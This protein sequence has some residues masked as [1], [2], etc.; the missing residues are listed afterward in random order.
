M[1]E[2]IIYLWNSIGVCLNS[3]FVWIKVSDWFSLKDVSEFAGTLVP[4]LALAWW[5]IKIFQ[6]IKKEE[7][8]KN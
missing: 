7:N 3:F 8:E 6:T 1:R 5:C 4:I 2:Y